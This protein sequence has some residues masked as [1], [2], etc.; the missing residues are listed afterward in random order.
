MPKP[1]YPCG[2]VGHRQPSNRLQPKAARVSWS[3][4]MPPGRRRPYWSTI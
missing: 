1:T 3:T 4:S 2:Y